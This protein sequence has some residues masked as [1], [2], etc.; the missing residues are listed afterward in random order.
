M[1]WNIPTV[2][3]ADELLDKAFRASS[4][5]RPVN[6]WERSHPRG[7]YMKKIGA[8]SSIIQ[9]KFATYIRRFPSVNVLEV[10]QGDDVR[11]GIGHFYYDLFEIT[12]GIDRMKKS[13]GA[14]DWA[15]KKTRELESQHVKQIKR[16]VDA[17]EMEQ[18]RSAFYGR[19]SSVVKQVDKDLTFLAKAREHIRKMPHIDEN[20]IVVVVAGAPNVGKSSLIN[21]ISSGNS[22][23]ASYPFT[24]KG[25]FLGH[26]ELART[27]VVLVDTPGLLER[28]ESERNPIERK[29]SSAIRNL[30]SAVIFM[31]DPSETSGTPI[32]S[33][34]T[35][36]AQLKE[37]LGEVPNITV[38][39]KCD[40]L[41][42]E[43]GREPGSE[44]EK[45]R[46][47]R[48]PESESEK[49]TAGGD[50]GSKKEMGQGGLPGSGSDQ[51]GGSG[52]L[53]LSCTTGEGKEEVMAWL[54]KVV[55]GILEDDEGKVEDLDYEA[56]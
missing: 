34:E 26:L 9:S 44:S 22:Q 47:G 31:L 49:G 43:T 56:E 53:Q 23:I 32:G 4:K 19:V 33:Q 16:M 28:P 1:R 11:S 6:T 17:G 2:L 45:E 40:L 25:I 48:E 18:V 35:L 42:R 38:E 29:A 7:T 27:K 36:L 41:R 15:V 51:D 37:E 14:L 52:N 24:T 55:R 13:L 20:A 50:T 21:I 5:I 12:F 10:Y 46:V 8:I 3:T 39:N 30:S 54:E